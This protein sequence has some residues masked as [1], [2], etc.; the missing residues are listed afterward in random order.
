MLSAMTSPECAYSDVGT[1]W[2][3]VAFIESK[4]FHPKSPRL[5]ATEPPVGTQSHFHWRN[6]YSGQV[7]LARPQKRGALLAHLH[8]AGQAVHSSNP[9]K[10]EPLLAVELLFWEHAIYY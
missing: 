3:G 4:Q 9:G 2:L 6:C 8:K 10:R 7:A 5:T 1:R